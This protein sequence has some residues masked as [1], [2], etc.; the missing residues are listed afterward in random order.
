MTIHQIQ[1]QCRAAIASIASQIAPGIA[2]REIR[3][4]CEKYLLSNG[5]ESF[6]YWNVGA[7]VF[8]GKDTVLSLSGRDYQT[9]DRTIGENDI[10]TIDLSPQCQSV[11]GDYARTLIVE[12]G[13]VVPAIDAI[14]TTEWRRGLLAQGQLHRFMQ[15]FVSPDTTFEELFFA[16]N[17]QIERMGYRNLDFCGNL[18]HSIVRDK[19]DRIYIEKGNTAKLSAVEAFTFEPH[20]CAENG[21]FGYKQEDI[22][23]FAQGRLTTL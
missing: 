17:R 19:K 20:I 6:W 21:S 13:R 14:E 22:Y 11:W 16:A 23:C 1:N 12:H 9:A 18:G 4:L 2:L 5:A 3:D 7:F 15:D 10:I 8:S